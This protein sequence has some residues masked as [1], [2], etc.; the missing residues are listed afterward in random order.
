MTPAKHR[1]PAFED[2]RDQLA[3]TVRQSAVQAR[4]D[5]LAEQGQVERP[6]PEG[7]GPE[8]VR[9]LDLIQE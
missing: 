1:P 3:Q 7:F 9:Q 5:E 8:V 2:I 6:A 4:I